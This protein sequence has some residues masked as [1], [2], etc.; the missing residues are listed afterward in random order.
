MTALGDSISGYVRDLNLAREEVARLAAS[1]PLAQST[2]TRYRQAYRRLIETRTADVGNKNSAKVVRSAAA[3]MLEQTLLLA[4][5]ELELI[6]AY[7]G[8]QEFR[9]FGQSDSGVI[10]YLEARGIR[11]TGAQSSELR[12]RVPRVRRLNAL[13]E[14]WREEMLAAL[15]TKLALAREAVIVLG[16]TGC[17]PEELRSAE[18]EVEEDGKVRITVCSVKELSGIRRGAIFVQDGLAR[19]ISYLAGCTE[20]FADFDA[21]KIDN[22]LRRTSRAAF[23]KLNPE[24]CASCFRNQAASDLKKARATEQEIA[25]FLGH[26][27]TRQQKTYGRARLGRAGSAWLPSQILASHDVRESESSLAVRDY[28]GCD[29]DCADTES[30]Y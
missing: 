3:Y 7:R 10:D 26:T 2:S 22:L 6:K 9:R 17:R 15:S 12:P 14:N 18:V 29:N 24:V 4:E 11:V 16:L 27:T 21:K 8:L 25:L 19:E 28:D 23:P 5:M 1:R 30:D 20:P 13:P